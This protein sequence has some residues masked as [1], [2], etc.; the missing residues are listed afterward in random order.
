MDKEAIECLELVRQI[1]QDR[2]ISQNK[3]LLVLVL[4]IEV[5]SKDVVQYAS[6]CTGKLFR[7]N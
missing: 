6:W 3:V 4:R 1:F 7:R 2:H 5:L